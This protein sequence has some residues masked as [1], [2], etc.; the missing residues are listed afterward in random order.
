MGH[1]TETRRIQFRGQTATF[2]VSFFKDK[3]QTQPL[4]PLDASQYPAYTV[5]NTDNVAVQSGIGQPVSGP[6]HYKAEFIVPEDAPLSHDEKR[7]R[8]EWQMVSTE[9]RQVDL[10]EEFD[11]KD[12]VIKA[13]E[14]REQKFIGLNGNDYRAMLRL[15]LEPAELKLDVIRGVDI[16]NKIVDNVSL[17]SNQLKK[18]VDGDSYVFYYDIPGADIN[19]GNTSYSMIWKVRV[20]PTD[21]ETFTY[22]VLTTVSPNVLQLIASVRI[23]IDKFQKALGTYQAYED[24]DIVEYLQRGAELFN[25]SYPL[26]NYDISSIPSALSVFHILLSSWYALN[27]QQLLEIDLGFD[28]SGQTVTLNYDH[29]SQ[30]ADVLGRWQ[31]YITENLP[32]AKM[33]Y[34]RRS[35][36]VGTTAGRA[37]RFTDPN[38][39]TYK[40]SSLSGVNSASIIGQLNTLGLLF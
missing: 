21:V 28:F 13:S 17:A 32:K 10:V 19:F 6:G 39:F 38:L 23:L 3:N 35:Q 25:S 8:I 37:Y 33:G 34:V 27:A 22:Q 9:N 36:S 31:T 30:L 4:I 16:N 24:S 40:I 29:S 18:A 1:T 20:T 11:V 2:K 15:P 14:S 26:T 12:T 5:Y 7:W